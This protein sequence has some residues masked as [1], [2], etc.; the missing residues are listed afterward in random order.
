MSPW[1]DEVFAAA[2]HVTLQSR[3][4]GRIEL[5][6]GRWH[7]PPGPAD[8]ALLGRARGAVLDIGCG[9]GRL[10]H[11][12]VLA[13]RTALGIDVSAAAVASTR[14]R[15]APAVHTSVFGP[16]PAAGRW[17]TALLLDGN[18]GIGGNACSLLR[19]T[20]RLVAPDGLILV[21]VE[22]PAAVSENVEVRV[23]SGSWFPWSRIA[24]GDVPALANSA[25]LA[26]DE[27]WEHSGRWFAAL[28]RGG[29]ADSEAAS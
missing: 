21:E 25:G 5:D 28:A 26:L 13:G 19:Q 6:A 4:G 23:G 17:G 8:L 18:I 14:R 11:A 24:A 20:A 7:A 29:L 15:G 27:V 12:L 16:V 2:G 3:A 1:P 9:P 10:V 22:S